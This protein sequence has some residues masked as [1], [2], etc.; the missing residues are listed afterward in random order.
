MCITPARSA[1]GRRGTRR[2]QMA[3]SWPRAAQHK[4]IG[5][6]FSDKTDLFNKLFLET[7]ILKKCISSFY[8]IHY[9]DDIAAV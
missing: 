2:S 7:L 9:F 8:V 1:F 5:L 4:K 6:T 3:R